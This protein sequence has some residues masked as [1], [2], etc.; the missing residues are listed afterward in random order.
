MLNGVCPT[1][2]EPDPT[3]EGCCR[4]IVTPPGPVP[5]PPSQPPVSTPEDEGDEITS[6]LCAQMA[7]NT[8]ALISAIE[9]LSLGSGAT[10]DPTCCANVVSAIGAVAFQLNA[11]LLAL[12]GPTP[13]ATITFAPNITI[14]VPP[15]PPPTINVNDAP[16][17]QAN[18]DRIAKATET[19]AVQGDVPLPVLK[20]L[21][22]SGILPPS[23][24]DLLQGS[25][26]SEVLAGIEAWKD[27]VA[28]ATWWQD[29]SYGLRLIQKLNAGYPSTVPAPSLDDPPLGGKDAATA[30]A[31]GVKDMI[32]FGFDHVN[33]ISA[34]LI[35]GMLQAHAD[36]I[37]KMR[38][39]KPGDEVP[40]ATNLLGEASTFGIGAHLAACFGELVYPSK[41]VG[42]PQLAATLA[43]FSGYEELIKGYLGSEIRAVITAPHTYATNARARPYLPGAREAL[44]LS[45][46]RKLTDVDL[47]QLLDYAG[48]SP[49]Y[50]AA[51]DAGKYRPISPRALA[52]LTL[53]QPFDRAQMQE[54]LEDNS[55]SPDH[56]Q[57]MLDQL[58]Y[59]S[60]KNVRNS[61]IGQA[62]TAY[63]QGV[64]G[65]DEMHQIVIDAGWSDAAW[66]LVKQ[67][68][69]IERRMTL[70]SEVE[71]QVIPLVANGNITA[72]AGLQQLEAA[73][74]QDWYAQ[75]VI[76]L[77]TTKAEIHAAKLE[78]AAEAKLERERQV[79][80]TRAATSEYQRG[81]LDLPALGASL[82]AIGLDP[83]LAASITAVQDATRAGK[84]RFMFGQFLTPEDAK[85][86]SDR[87][88]AIEGQFKKQLL[89]RDAAA[90]Q[91]SGLNL[92][93]DQ[94]AALLAR[95]AA[96]LVA[97]GKYSYLLS[98]LTG[99]PP[100]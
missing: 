84:L 92:P 76:T 57:F 26:W 40:A 68:I 17:D 66:Q 11:I 96:A 48:V 15:A 79:N 47:A 10:P 7:V 49:T 18:L 89:S 55:M 5:I 85:V 2:Y 34:P 74:V 80:L 44:T 14:D 21:I 38:D 99:Q 29:I 51:E 83:T 77:A 22:Q 35:S 93:D 12:P 69:L 1:G 75:L 19:M 28:H 56:V 24:G 82:L 42:F 37:R 46:R 95:W 88:A 61:L 86:L 32:A 91:L 65:D 54:I 72:D 53:D 16:F 33:T 9:G 4:P 87:V 3:D 50:R 52:T 6:T 90:A 36:E 60:T 78:A 45:A 73:G 23:M 43:L 62:E 81:V 39:V 27:K 71:K 59:N 63:K 97:T 31:E 41:S 94:V 100:T 64:I 67:K 58:E 70:A 20:Q 98:P 25:P 30:F 13:P 8:T